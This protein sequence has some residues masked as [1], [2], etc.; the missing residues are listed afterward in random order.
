M[1]KFILKRIFAAALALLLAVLPLQAFAAE[2]LTGIIAETWK[3]VSGGKDMQA[4]LDDEI[5]ENAGTSM[6][7]LVI[8]LKRSGQELDYGNYIRAAAAK[9]EENAISNPVTRMQC[10]L[11]LLAC[12]AVDQ[13][14]AALAQESIGKLGVMSFVY[15]L[16]LLNNGL[17]CEEWTAETLADALVKLQ[18]ADGGWAVTGAFGDVDVTSM[19]IQ[20]LA[21]CE[22]TDSIRSALDRAVLFLSEAQLD[23][24]GFKSYGKENSESL[25]Q[26]MLAIA[27]LGLDP[28]GEAQYIK[29]GR[30]LVD[31]LLDYRLRGSGFTHLPG[32]EENQMAGI[33]A[34]QA[35][36]A[37][38]RPGVVYYDFSAEEY[39]FV[40]A[41][42]N[43]ALPAW[44]LAA[45]AVIGVFALAG[46]IFALT[47][48]H[49]RLKQLFFV[50][51]LAG[52]LAAAVCMIQIESTADYYSAPEKSGAKGEVYLSISCE[53]AVGVQD[54]GSIP[55]DGV[56]L[57]R[58]A[59]PLDEDDSIFDIL[60]D[61]VK[62]YEIQMEH[63][64]GS[65]D[66]AYVNGIHYLYEFVNGDLSG[67]V[68]TVNGVQPSIGCGAYKPEPGD[69]IIWHYT[70][71]LGEDI[72]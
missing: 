32:E 47:R 41:T 34:L 11:S 59:M 39:P 42:E 19:C 65:G 2:D 71:E 44:K 56:I 63:A 9:L 54:D 57:P 27:S 40:V 8:L 51:I 33:Q 66:L 24:G 25:C 17:A 15:G 52:I 26:V 60:I 16:H 18:K 43:D 64:G 69:E 45:F 4:W 53:K 58:T 22:Q 55:A 21:A 20:A 5:A 3:H 6:D 29:N 10:A 48:R 31:V 46:C 1:M 35:M 36:I 62:K 68:Y 38:L 28:A 23:N 50:L 49:G 14:P 13:V 7:S 72:Q 70:L 30:N 12:G 37:C 61:A 67:W